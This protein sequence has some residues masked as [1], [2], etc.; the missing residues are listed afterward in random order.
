MW[1]CTR[2]ENPVVGAGATVTSLD[3][4]WGALLPRTKNPERPSVFPQRKQ[5]PTLLFRQAVPL[6]RRLPAC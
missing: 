3:R 1:S 6:W 5:T 4:G 2:R